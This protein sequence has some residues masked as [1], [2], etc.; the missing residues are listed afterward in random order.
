MERVA[1]LTAS[2]VLLTASFKHLAL[3]CSMLVRTSHPGRM[4]FSFT[5]AVMPGAWPLLLLA[6]LAGCELA[7]GDAIFTFANPAGGEQWPVNVAQTIA[8]R[9]TG[10]PGFSNTVLYLKTYPGLAT[11]QDIY[12]SG[13]LSPVELLPLKRHFDPLV[14]AIANVLS[15]HTWRRLADWTVCGASRQSV[16][17][18]GSDKLEP[19]HNRQL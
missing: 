17:R 4:K 6:L 12:T 16:L 10:T 2:F 19:I 7:N 11:V 8:W 3:P 13:G 14:S 9:Y 15:I 18:S 5:C 1:L